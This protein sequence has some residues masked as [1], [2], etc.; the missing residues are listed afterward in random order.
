MPHYYGHPYPFM[1][2]SQQQFPPVPD[3]P[4]GTIYTVRPGDTMFKI[5]N[6]FEVSLQI[7]IIANPQVSNPNVLYPGQQLCIPAI[8]TP[9]PPQPFCTNGTIYTVQRGDTLFSIA[10]NYDVTVQQMIQANPQIADPN[11]I[12][13][14]QRVCIP[15]TVPPPD[16]GIC[17]INLTPLRQGI[18]GGTAFL[19]FSDPTLWIAV[20]GLPA[21]ADIDPKYCTY[22]AWLV[23]Q[24]RD[25]YLPIELKPSGEPGIEV[26]YEKIMRNLMGFTEI[27]VT[28]EAT[29]V[30]QNPM[31]P[32]LL[33]GAI[34]PC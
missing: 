2:R 3:C 23:N 6:E 9:P 30:Q 22:R 14:G 7:L 11:V 21:P 16:Q 33:K 19:D 8:V 18:L 20:F 24:E 10:R 15:K 29:P 12:Q 25:V 5:A 26:G 4:G 13:V 28:P 32:I 31:G 34:G 17:E 1:V 27:I